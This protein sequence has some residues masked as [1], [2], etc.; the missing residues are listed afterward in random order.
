VKRGTAYTGM[1]VVK[2]SRN[3]GYGTVIAG[4]AIISK[5]GVVA[6]GSRPPG[7]EPRVPIRGAQK[8]EVRDHHVAVNKA[9]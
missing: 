3:V 9:M 2:Q 6:H 4:R 7:R 8:K 5:T 1:Q